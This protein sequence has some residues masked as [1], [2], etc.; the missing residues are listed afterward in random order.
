[1]NNTRG[2]YRGK[3][4]DK[5]VE[6]NYLHLNDGL[7]YEI[8]IIVD[9]TGQYKRIDNPETIG[10]CTGVKDRYGRLIYEGDIIESEEGAFS[11][12]YNA[13]DGAFIAQRI[14]GVSFELMSFFDSCEIV[15]NVH[16]AQMRWGT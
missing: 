16:E 8:D 14:D 13:E 6:G 10:E 15:G 2:L 12:E 7:E 11:I 9:A 1:M 4:D 5:W 3:H